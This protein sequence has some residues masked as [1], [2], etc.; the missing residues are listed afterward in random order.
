MKNRNFSIN[1]VI[2][3]M[4]IPITL[5]YGIVIFMTY[6]YSSELIK[7]MGVTLNDYSIWALDISHALYGYTALPLA[8]FIL[9]YP[10]FI[11]SKKYKVLILNALLWFLL[12]L[13]FA[14]SAPLLSLAY[15]P[16]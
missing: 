16:Q 3:F 14:L 9:F 15:N 11:E 7:G 6:P 1:K 13:L 8:L 5:L 12:Y 4:T 10:F 2:F